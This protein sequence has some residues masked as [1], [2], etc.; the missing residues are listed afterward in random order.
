MT[1]QFLTFMYVKDRKGEK[2]QD[3]G[4]QDPCRPEHRH[5]KTLKFLDQSAFR[6]PPGRKLPLIVISPSFIPLPVKV[7]GRSYG[8][9][10]GTQQPHP[11]IQLIYLSYLFIP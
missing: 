4:I 10:H 8:K 2:V 11:N 6:S 3:F 5:T 1:T 9:G 7:I